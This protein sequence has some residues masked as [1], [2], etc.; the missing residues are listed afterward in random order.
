MEGPTLNSSS[1]TLTRTFDSVVP[2][3]TLS[4]STPNP[5]NGTISVTAQFS[6]PVTGFLVGD[7]AVGNGVAGSFV[8]VD[9]DT[10]TFVVTPGAQGSVT[11]GVAAGVATDAAGNQNTA[12]TTLAYT[13]DSIAPAVAF[14]DVNGVPQS[15]PYSTPDPIT[16]LA[17]ECG[18]ETD[19]SA[20]VDIAITGPLAESG[21]TS[22]ESGSWSYTL[23]TE[24][25]VE[26]AYAAVV[27]QTDA[28]GNIGSDTESVSVDNPPT[29]DVT[30]TAAP[31]AVPESG[32]TV[33]FRSPSPT[34]LPP[35][36]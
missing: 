18:T 1:N 33:T 20:T 34:P 4:S 6:E 27:T 35:T 28:A 24:L 17:G 25:T 22:C 7:I 9:G 36:R 30:V 29:A 11:I 3:L 32:A 14:E 10:Y 5:T 31:T 15:F 8:A 16:S 19:D 21:S 23:L 13:Y 2:S 26:G 12:A